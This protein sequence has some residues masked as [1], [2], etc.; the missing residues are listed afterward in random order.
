[1]LT[2]VG[3]LWYTDNA[4]A[5]ELCSHNQ[6][7]EFFTASINNDCF[8]VDLN[9]TSSRDLPV[10]LLVPQPCTTLVTLSHLRHQCQLTPYTRL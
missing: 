8:T 9:C 4:T 10:I 2:Y 3:A 7:V 6:S 5:L 1:M